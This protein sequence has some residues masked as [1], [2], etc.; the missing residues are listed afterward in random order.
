MERGIPEPVL[1]DLTVTALRDY[2]VESE[3]F[4]QTISE[5]S[6]R[7]SALRDDSQRQALLARIGALDTELGRLTAAIVAGR[8]PASI[9]RAIEERE[10]KKVALEASGMYSRVTP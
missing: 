8:A 4:Q 7:W 3:E 6:R 1:A 9:V 2:Y 10:Q 5:H